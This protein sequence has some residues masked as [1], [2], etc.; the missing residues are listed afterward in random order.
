MTKMVDMV[1]ALSVLAALAS[2]PIV[3]GSGIVVAYAP[4]WKL[5][6]I[7]RGGRYVYVYDPS[8][9]GMFYYA[10]QRSVRVKPGDIVSPGQ[11]IG[12]VGR[13]GRNAAAPR[14][15]THL[16]AMFLAID[17]AGRP[18]PRDIYPDLVRLG[19]RTSAR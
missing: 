19:H 14:S 11:P 6:S 3:G 2:S 9:K 15:P 8:Q 5:G 10:H 16:H 1:V 12:T 17:G 4:E 7:L 13:S 18:A